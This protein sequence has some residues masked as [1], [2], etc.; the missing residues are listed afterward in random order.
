MRGCK[1]RETV[2][3]LDVQCGKGSRGKRSRVSREKWERGQGG[4]GASG[5][6]RRGKGEKG[7]RGKGERGKGGKGGEK[8][9]GGASVHS[10][11]VVCSFMSSPTIEYVG[12]VLE[13][14]ALT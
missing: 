11:H 1:R 13:C 2:E 7:K 14:G 5:K 4:K 10:G 3:G 6:G 12:G 9:L 8:W